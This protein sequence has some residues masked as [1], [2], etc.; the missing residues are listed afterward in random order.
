MSLATVEPFPP[1]PAAATIMVLGGNDRPRAHA[2]ELLAGAGFE[3]FT[4]T[5]AA[6]LHG[7]ATLIA[8]L[9]DGT[10]STR[11]AAIRAVAAA[12]P[13]TAVLAV[14]PA[15]ARAATL[16]RA[17]LAGAT[18]IV[19]DDSVDE[20]LVATAAAVLAGQLAVP[21]I[22]SRQIAPQPLSH[23]EREVI[24]LVVLGLTNQQ[25]AQ[26]LYLAESTVKT[27]LSSAFRKLDARSR[28]EAVA[29]LQDPEAG[30][31]LGPAGLHDLAVVPSGD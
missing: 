1:A 15:D 2:A 9:G 11:L 5:S 27:H 19:L 17:L 18:G 20:A 6:D 13:A 25:I 7:P 12:R 26:R 23:R 16:R 10:E 28:S 22:L 8:L 24:D 30:Y 14:M 3:I 31:G 4:G 21:G 29:R